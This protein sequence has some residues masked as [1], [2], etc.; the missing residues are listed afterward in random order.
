MSQP[1]FSILVFMDCFFSMFSLESWGI[2]FSP[3][4]QRPEWIDQV[5]TPTVEPKTCA[6]TGYGGRCRSFWGKVKCIWLVVFHQPI[7]KRLYSQ[8]G[9][10]FPKFRGETS[11]KY[12]SCH[13]LYVI[14][15]QKNT[16]PLAMENRPFM[17]RCI[18]YWNMGI[19]SPAMLASGSVFSHHWVG[20]FHHKQLRKLG[21][22]EVP[23]HKFIQLSFVHPTWN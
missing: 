20:V 21:M 8:N 22:K 14:P 13:H 3:R 7:C 23:V 17:S 4:P 5:A 19:F 9:N 15:P 12:L 16:R 11:K 1:S 6:A 10:I 2:L 18:S